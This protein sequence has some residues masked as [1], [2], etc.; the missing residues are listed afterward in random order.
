MDWPTAALLI[1]SIISAAGAS[2]VAM[3]KWSSKPNGNG[4]G[5]GNGKYAPLTD[6]ARLQERV[7]HVSQ[8]MDRM[9]NKQD[10]MRKDF[11]AAFKVINE[12]MTRYGVRL[13]SHDSEIRRIRKLHDD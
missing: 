11:L 6:M 7:S 2:I 3:L 9:E 13:D 10:E 5:N 1:T 8:T 4:N 12:T